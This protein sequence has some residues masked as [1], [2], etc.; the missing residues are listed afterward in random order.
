VADRS[1]TEHEERSIRTRQTIRIL[2][3]VVLVAIVVAFA[4]DNSQQVEVGWL[5][6]SG[7]VALWIVIVA[8]FVVGGIAGYVA[9]RRHH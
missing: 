1:V 9:G 3:V 7:D 6:G 5:F 2:I 4:V 8:S